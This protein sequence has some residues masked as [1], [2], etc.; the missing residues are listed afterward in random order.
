[1]TGTYRPYVWDQGH[2]MRDLNGLL[3]TGSGWIVTDTRGINDNGEIVTLA[4]GNDGIDHV[5]LLKPITAA[6]P[7]GDTVTVTPSATVPV[8]LTFDTV[9]GGGQTTVTTTTSA[10]AL[11]EGFQASGTFINITT[12]A[13]FSGPITDC[14]P[15]NAA[16]FR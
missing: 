1:S 7:T 12:S 14:T 5:V 10:P 4:M 15:Y 2:G 6:T 8:T 13:T 3:A 9:L 16:V 11:P